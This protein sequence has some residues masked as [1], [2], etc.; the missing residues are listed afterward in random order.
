MIGVNLSLWRWHFIDNQMTPKLM[1]YKIGFQVKEHSIKM[2]KKNLTL[3]RT[4][5]L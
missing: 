4:E 2:N 1:V 5:I 3:S